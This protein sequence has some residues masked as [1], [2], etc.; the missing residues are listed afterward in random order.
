VGDQKPI[1]NDEVLLYIN[2]SLRITKDTLKALKDMRMLSTTGIAALLPLLVS[3]IFAQQSPPSSPPSVLVYSAT[4]GYRHDSIPTAIEALQEIADRTSLY[5]PTFSED[6]NLFTTEGLQGFKAIVFLSNSDQVLTSE[7]ESAFE[8]WLTTSGGSLVG[9][10]AATACLFN[11]TAFGTA[12]GSWFHRHPDIQNV[13][14]LT[15]LFNLFPQ[16]FIDT[17]E[18]D[19]YETHRP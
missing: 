15:F 11:D 5:D 18:T 17:F 2:L 1:W 13:V 16:R 12:M 19:F 7:G 4:A 8:D 10:H 3:P 6:P 14:S 9:L